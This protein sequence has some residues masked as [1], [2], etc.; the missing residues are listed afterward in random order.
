MRF[1]LKIAILKSG[2]TQREVSVETG[3]PETRL[4]AIVRGRATPDAAEQDVL[5]RELS[6]SP[7]ALFPPIQ[8]VA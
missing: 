1:E 6:T 4:S 8:Q 7:L 2:K 5:A 3:I